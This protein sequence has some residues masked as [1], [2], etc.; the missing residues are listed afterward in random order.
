MASEGIAAT[1]VPAVVLLGSAVVMVPLFKRIGLG[2]VLGYFAGGVLVG[3]SVLGLFRDP[4]A[5]LHLSELGVV[6]FLF[7]IG[8]EMKPAR[9]WALRGQ[10]FGLG[11]AQVAACA[12]LLTL[13][14]AALGLP[15]MVAFI[16]GSGFVLSSTAVI[17]SVL[18]E[19]GELASAQGQQGVSILLLEDL[20]I[21]PLLMLVAFLAPAGGAGGT[22]LGSI[23]I[24][25]GAVAAV[26]AAWRWLL[27]PMFALLARTR[28]NEVLTA[29]ALLVV[30]GAALLMDA[31]GLSMAMGA[32]LAGVTLSGSSY[33][34]Q[35]ETDVGPFKGLLM[36]LFF[37]AVGM[38]L[39]LALVA[40]QGA[41][42]AALLAAFM[43]A[44]AAGIYIIAR[45]F[46]AGGRDALRRVAMFV[47]GG[48]FAFVLFAAALGGGLIG[49]ADHAVLT[50]VVIL[51]MALTPLILLAAERALKPGAP[52]MTGVDHAEGLD[53]QVLLIGFG[54]FG[55]L[56]GQLLLRHGL[57]VAAID[58]DPHRIRE[59][60][61]FGFKVY[62]GD[63]T[64]LDVLRQ[65]GADK[66]A[67]ILV[68][69]D[70]AAGATRIAQLARDH[71]PLAKLV[72]RSFDRRHSIALR[73][74]GVDVEV[75]ETLESA[76]ALGAAAL[77]QLGLDALSAATMADAIRAADAARLDVQTQL[78][79][80]EPGQ[81]DTAAMQPEPL[82]SR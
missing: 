31:A 72:V 19:R 80:I 4:Q 44:K 37:L 68:C 32:F 2:S 23:A 49:A 60:E 58:N 12:V 59:A 46:G 69:I 40:A 10:I 33:R 65:S 15:L 36:G 39:D 47:Q 27:D 51:S 8:V 70:D 75:R 73:Q 53:G 18:Q 34:H 63:G 6:M 41:W 9:L 66:A 57:R 17:M 21:V 52:D 30:L 45:L 29:G 5:I 43:T 11:L 76:I 55:Q 79:K 62:Y 82:T 1:L 81:F 54:R 22:I 50:A 3:P 42:I 74:I 35:I 64:R 20:M 13:A 24:G 56:A 38:S 25:I 67:A 48:E 71:F 61:R 78:G 16:G 26:I 77:E 14:G 28:I 7:L